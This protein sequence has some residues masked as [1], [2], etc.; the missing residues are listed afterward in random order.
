[1]LLRI[2]PLLVLFAAMPVSAADVPLVFEKDV[3]PI[4]KQHCFQCHGEEPKPKGSLDLRTVKMMVKGGSDGAAV[5][6]GKADESLIWTRVQADEMPEGHKKVP[7]IQKAILKKWIDQ[8]AK[9]ARAEPDNPNDAKFSEE[10]L[11]HWAWQPV[12]KVAVPSVK[13]ASEH[14]ID[15]FLMANLSKNGIHEFS[16]QADRRTLIRRAT[17]DLTGLPPSPKEV[18]AFLADT[19][20]NAY[21]KL[22][23]RLLSIPQYGE[24][25]GRHW[26]DVAG[27]S[28]TDGSPGTD[29]DRPHAW[30]YR[31][32]VIRS[33]N[34]DKPYSQF[35]REQLAGDE[36]AAKPYRL[37]D[38]KT[39]DLLAATGFL[40]MA[41]DV[42]QTANTIIERNQATADS[43][44]VATTTFLGLTVGCAQCHDHKYDP[45]SAED[46]YRLRAVFDP[47]FNLTTWKK[48]SERLVDVTPKEALEP[49][50]NAEKLV[51]TSEDKLNAEKDVAAK[52]VFD[53]EVGRV[54]ETEREAVVRAITAEEKVRTP[55][56]V[57]LLKKH[58][59]VKST[60]F[61][62]GFFVE[63]DKKLD[64]TFKE[65]EAAIAKLRTGIETLH[66]KQ[67][68]MVVAESGAPPV[69][70]IHFRGDPEQPTKLVTAGELQVLSRTKTASIPTA[71]GRRLAYA[72]WLV[73]GDH[74]LTARVVANRIWMHHF[75]KGIV[76]TPSDFGLNGDRPTHPELLDW[77]ANEF[78]ASGWK[79][80][81][82]HKL[83]MTS[84]AYKQTAKR[85]PELNATDPDNRWLGRMNLR[86][87]DAESVRDAVL[88]ASGKLN[89]TVGGASTPV[90]EDGEGKVVF[91]HRKLND[92]LFTG[93]ESIGDAAF[94][95]SIYVQSRRALPLAMLEAFDLPVMTPNCAARRCSTVAPQA[96]FLLN[97]EF[98]VKQSE[99]MAE[100]L[101]REAPDTDARL[102]LCYRIL[103][104]A[105]PTSAEAKAG[106]LFVETQ[107]KGFQAGTDPAWKATLKKRPERAELRALA[108]LCQTLLCSNRFLYV[109]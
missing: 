60:T 33:F 54:P 98:I 36:L 16:P 87:L 79:I 44:R 18:D 39:V 85:T 89:R 73:Q 46:Y 40:R 58:P 104:A 42:T 31:D 101:F 99:E 1:M 22:L 7:P 53:R 108:S 77:L 72:D 67:Y 48:P 90:A 19:S 11:S 78:V 23:D 103:F 41:P 45:I 51:K 95:R 29:T 43:F 64:A 93:I 8:G 81:G 20:A 9:T 61:I 4:M 71:S 55:E 47:A 15:Q 35:L 82:F 3:R 2:V 83:L 30:R 97:D 74:P 105:E 5:V 28:E 14:P 92:G 34:D 88:A 24:R 12:A 86:R 70:K 84:A 56:Q 69:S 17:F 27:Y 76:G 62:R 26:L 75:G 66:P 68:L 80:K 10:E 25:W 96:L 109:D 21:E 52:V 106:K 32:Y 50:A 94:R 65:S 13:S 57:A 91:G 59:N 63:Y 38:P 49:I 107:A 37:N 102:K 6:P 100:R